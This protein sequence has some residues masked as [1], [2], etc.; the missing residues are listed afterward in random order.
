[1]YYAPHILQVKNTPEEV[2]DEFGRP[3]VLY[4]RPL[5]QGASALKGSTML[6]GLNGKPVLTPSQH[7]VASSKFLAAV[8]DQRYVNVCR[9]RCDSVTMAKT[10]T[11]DGSVVRPDY[12]VVTDGNRIKLKLGDVVRCIDIDGETICEGEILKLHRLNTL[13]YAEIYL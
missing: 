1:M 5:M 13:P 11:D 7:A 12:H 2:A 4:A 10:A 8:C 6:L 9:C 3:V